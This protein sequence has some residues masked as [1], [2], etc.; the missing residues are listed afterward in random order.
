MRKF[1]E[2]VKPSR[3]VFVKWPLGHPFGEPF[4]VRQHNAVIRKAFEALKTIKKPGT[5]IDL[6]FRWRRDEDWEDKN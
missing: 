3:A 5:I 4:K 1:T 6:P 2:E